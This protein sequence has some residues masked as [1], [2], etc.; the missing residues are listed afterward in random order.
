M[1]LECCG[2]TLVPQGRCCNGTPFEPDWQ[3]C[4]QGQVVYTRDGNECCADGRVVPSGQCGWPTC[5]GDPYDASTHGCCNGQLYDRAT[6][7]CCHDSQPYDIA[8]QT[9]CEGG[10]VVMNGEPCPQP[11]QLCGSTVYDPNLGQDCCNGTVIDLSS[12][13]CMNNVPV[14]RTSSGECPPTCG[15]SVY[16]P[17]ANQSCCNGY[18]YDY[19]THVCCGDGPVPMGYCCGAQ[20]FDPATQECCGDGTVAPTDQCGWPVC[21]G[22]RYDPNSGLECCNGQTYDPVTQV[23]CD[24]ATLVDI[25]QCHPSFCNNVPF[26][27][28]SEECCNGEIVPLGNCCGN[29][30]INPATQGCGGGQMI[31]DLATEDYC[32]DGR[33]VPKG[34]CDWPSCGG[35]PYDNMTYECCADNTLA[36]IGQCPPPPSLCN[37]QPYDPA[38]HDCC[39]D[40]RIVPSG[41]CNW[42]TCNG[43]P[44]D[45]D[46]QDCCSDGNIALKNQC[47][48]TA[49]CN[50]T[51][52]NPNNYE[53]CGE[54]VVP[55]G[56][57]CS[58]MNGNWTVYN[59]AIE[60]CCGGAGGMLV[61][62]RGTCPIE[63]GG[64]WINPATTGCCQSEPY[65]LATYKC[66]GTPTVHVASIGE[67]CMDYCG[68]ELYNTDTH[69]CCNNQVIPLS[70]L[71]Y[72]ECSPGVTYNPDTQE[73]CN[74]LVYTL[75]S[76]ECCYNEVVNKGE[77]PELSVWIN[78][79]GGKPCVTGV[80]NP[81][82]FIA[83]ASNAFGTVTYSWN[84]GGGH[85]TRTEGEGPINATFDGG[86]QAE[87]DVTATDT[88]I[89]GG[90]TFERF[91]Y[92][93]VIVN[94][95]KITFVHAAGDTA[96]APM[97][98]IPFWT[99]ND[100]V[101]K[102]PPILDSPAPVFQM[103]PAGATMSATFLGTDYALTRDQT[104]PL[105]YTDAS[106]GLTVR[107]N[108]EPLNDPNVAEY[109]EVIVSLPFAGI[110]NSRYAC[111]ETA[112]NSSVFTY[113][114]PG[115][116]MTVGPLDETQPDT[117]TL[118]VYQNSAAS[119]AVTETGANTLVFTNSTVTASLLC[120][121]SA[122]SPLIV[123]L[124]AAG[125]DLSNTVVQL[126]PY[127]GSV[128]RNFAPPIP[129]SM[130][131]ASVP[132]DAAFY[133]QVQGT[134]LDNAVNQPIT[135]SIGTSSGNVQ[136]GQLDLTPAS[137]G[138]WKTTSPSVLC[139]GDPM[140]IT[141]ADQANY[142]ALSCP[143]NVIL[144]GGQSS[145]QGKGV[146]VS[147][148]LP[149]VTIT[150][151]TNVCGDAVAIE[152]LQVQGTYRGLVDWSSQSLQCFGVISNLLVN[153][154]FHTYADRNACFVNRYKYFEGKEVWY[155]LM[156]GSVDKD[157][158][159]FN[160]LVTRFDSDYLSVSAINY[161]FQ[162]QGRGPMRLVIANSCCSAQTLAGHEEEASDQIKIEAAI[163][164]P[165]MLQGA[166]TFADAFISVGDTQLGAYVG[167][168]WFIGAAFAE[169][170]AA[171]F[172]SRCVGKSVNVGTAYGKLMTDFEETAPNIHLMMLYGA[173]SVV[174]D[175]RNNG[176]SPFLD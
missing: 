42:P 94:V 132:P 68:Q 143:P 2:N 92:T 72:P 73:C 170:A 133:V 41:Q 5:S 10:T 49:D 162:F 106:S 129:T 74:G 176:P 160:S 69:Q 97:D 33:V 87:V 98:Y 43:Q 23:C 161:V 103:T 47:N 34:Q 147:L 140:Q 51:I 63:C 78:T 60:D 142:T 113:T 108:Q 141:S 45:P 157:D 38:T 53:C 84:F 50:G 64:V 13:C 156:H 1:A 118:N 172:L 30:I 101:D 9:C 165:T 120:N 14:N 85:T 20:Y 154:G 76:Q 15:E 12:Q 114:P 164:N 123:A 173:N 93:N 102:G 169:S 111:D 70:D 88:F 136:I 146:V 44:Y 52:Y 105:F 89:R 163:A 61:A 86:G 8:T 25:G 175:L 79:D 77:C 28:G 159:L 96:G 55:I 36:A 174:V 67:P 80:G 119:F 54:A 125:F 117:V 134:N 19:T 100:G 121:P 130:P 58:D 109:L 24:G 83:S 75:A 158:G 99:P 167:W 40:G 110:T 107:L 150:T 4:C 37:G 124:T 90:Q 16:Y 3:D 155:S 135:L 21:G 17:E 62:P 29:Q 138:G 116:V 112:A 104:D 145:T 166:K 137:D 139:A 122:T 22:Q 6:Q 148:Q 59:P 149:N 153:L 91:A 18:V 65:S 151:S 144:G 128:Y 11:P 35:V 82:A 126:A 27:P 131:P 56:H 39:G 32:P 57:C 81:V 31:Y 7:D 26:D 152:S 171:N 168:K 66:C 95:A 115:L 127:G 48:D 46:T 71:C